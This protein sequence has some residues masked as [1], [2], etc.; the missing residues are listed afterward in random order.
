MKPQSVVSIKRQRTA[1][2]AK[3]ITRSIYLQKR[4][5]D[6]ELTNYISEQFLELGGVYIKFMQGIML[7]SDF[8][9]RWSNPNRFNIF[10]NLD[11]EIIKLPE[12][13]QKELPKSKLAE[14]SQVQPQPFAAG[15]FGQVYFGTLRDGT[16]II[17]KVLRPLIRETLQFDLKLINLFA[18]Q[19]LVKQYT[20]NLDIKL[21]TALDEFRRSTLLETDYV[22][23]ANFANEMYEAYKD[24]PKFIIPKT[25]L[26]LCTKNIIV[27]E[28]IGGIS[29]AQL[30]RLKA[31][32]VDPVKYIADNLGSDLD[33]QLITLGFELQYGIFALPR[34]QGDPHPGNVKFLE[35]NKVGLI[36]FGIIAPSP[37]NKAAFF[38][39][40]EEYA[41]IYEGKID[42]EEIFGK[43]IRFFA[44]DLYQAL[45]K[46]SY[47]RGTDHEDLNKM[48]GSMAK[49]AFSS[50]IKPADVIQFSDATKVMKIF[51]EVINKKNRFGIVMN[52]QSSEIIRAGSTYLTMVDALE[53]NKYVIPKMFRMAVEKLKKDIPELSV[54]SSPSMSMSRSVETVSKWLERVAMRDPDLFKSFMRHVRGGGSNILKGID[55]P[56]TEE[57]ENLNV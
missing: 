36:D 44:N 48:I 15:S 53:R 40:T 31:S 56:K 42:I 27:Q 12:V 5:R 11:T 55:K 41:N 54:E 46:I 19:F 47:S 9:K 39:L 33:E 37:K 51:N 18:K 22:S 2:M 23:E 4:H 50:R 3:I 21:D 28:Y 32:G 26:D 13:L 35:E 20:G 45:Q 52:V 24:N 14:I 25:Y 49:K 8:F 1:K 57:K 16:P 34:I 17:I 7:Q 43:F 30:I 10:E 29:G 6:A 38:A